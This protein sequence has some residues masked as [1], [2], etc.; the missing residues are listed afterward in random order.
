MMKKL[1][2]DYQSFIHKSRYSRW[3]EKEKRREEWHETVERY[4][5]FVV[6]HLEENYQYKL[7]AKL[8]NQ[9]REYILNL[10]VMPSMRAMMAAGEALKRENLAGYN[11]SYIQ[12]DNQRVFS[13]ILYV[14]MNGTGSGFSV[15]RQFVSQLPD[16]PSEI[17]DTETVIK[18]RDSKIGWAKALKEL[19]ALLY[20]GQCPKYDLSQIRPKGSILKTFG[21]RASGP[22]PLDKLFRFI[23][24]TFKT[25]VSNNQR[26]LSSIQCHDIICTVGNCVVSGGVRRS[27]LISLSNLSDDRMRQ[28]KMGQWWE[29][30]PQRAL[31]NNSVAYTE[32]P[33]MGMF[34][35]EWKALYDSKSGER[36]IFS[37]YG[38]TKKAKENGRRDTEGFNYGTNPCLTG[39]TLVYVADGRGFVSFSEL[40][41]I[42]ED[43]PV[44]CFDEK[45][46]IVVRKMRNPRITG[47]NKKILEIELEN[48]HKIKCTENHKFLDLNGKY[49]EASELNI[50]DSL[51]T[52]NVSESKRPNSKNSYYI[53]EYIKSSGKIKCEFEH[54]PIARYNFDS[55]L[56]GLQVHHKDFNGLNN[57]SSNLE[58]VTFKEHLNLHRNN[59]VGDNNPMRRA[60]TEWTAE[61]RNEY[62]S[63][64]SKSTSGSLNGNSLSHISNDDIRKHAIILTEKLG[65]RFSRGQWGIYAKEN[66][67]PQHFSKWRKKELG[68]IGV[69]A[70]WASEECGISP[71]LDADPRTQTKYRK[72]LEQGYDVQH[73]GKN[74]LFNLKC[75]SCEKE[76]VSYYREKSYCS[77]K[78]SPRKQNTKPKNRLKL[79]ERHNHIRKEQSKIFNELKCKLER[80]PLKNEWKNECKK[81]NISFEISRKSSPF[82]SYNDLINYS[83]LI[84]H[85]IINIKFIGYENVYNGTVDDFHNFFIG[86]FEETSKNKNHSGW[87]KSYEKIKT[88]V[89]INSKNCG[90]IILRPQELCNLS[91]VVVRETDTPETL[92]KK[93]EIATILGT[94][95][96]TLTDFKFVSSDWKKNCEEERL[97]GVSLT[98]VMDC[99]LT[100]SV[101]DKTKKLLSSLKDVAIK[102][103]KKWSTKLNINQSV[104]ITC[105]KPSG[106]I[107]QLVD[108]SS[109]IHTRHSEYYIRTVRADNSDPLCKFMIENG[110]PHEKCVTNP[111]YVTVFSFPMKSPGGSIT[112]KDLS[113]IEQLELWK[114]YKEYWCEHNPSVTISVRENEWM[115]VGSWVYENFDDITGVSFLPY[116]DHIYAQAPYSDLT[117]EQYDD[118]IKK[119]PKNI[120]WV[121]LKEYESEDNTTSTQELSCTA[122]SCE[123]VDITK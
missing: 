110:F 32:K 49:I 112:R 97:L 36:G 73:D 106:T 76:F 83:E 72:L 5:N 74:F 58:L 91:E 34:L 79:S 98:G 103:N 8:K 88:R 57:N 96:S 24:H 82:K 23:I 120:D 77:Q 13:E 10:E 35:T 53:H 64:M 17:F 104:A 107:S 119:M 11:C 39:D 84:N 46:N 4:L 99:S 114:M 89:C 62:S 50:G 111:D 108:C 55:K 105:C 113:A 31:A 25:A 101:N 48:G 78:C 68:G 87:Y 45:E 30:N 51:K 52:I 40:V 100:N 109:G 1:P 47:Y 12:V 69:L 65:C 60:K 123:V 41:E 56:A 3:L 7:N 85:K 19:I 122:G 67:L 116:S 22:E 37:R 90:E 14:L 121:K 66:G 86:G 26:K 29:D 59:M 18:V 15:E 42:G 81:R 61:K 43:V 80:I 21:G 117:K 9:I 28:A 44:F 63:K 115:Q 75:K 118:M 33:E 102:T 70:K 20:S 27:A 54:R 92:K 94:I 95:Q 6:E 2:T 93:V 16:L 71:L 38:A